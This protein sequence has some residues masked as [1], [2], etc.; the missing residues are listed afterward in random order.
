[1]P[2]DEVDFEKR[3]WLPYSGW[4]FNRAHLLLANLSTGG[5]SQTPNKERMYYS[6]EVLH[7]TKQAPH[8]DNRVVL[9]AECDKL[10]RRKAQMQSCWRNIDIRGVRWTQ[11][12]FAQGI[13][14]A[15]L[16]NEN[17]E[18]VGAR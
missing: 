13:A 15:G 6:F 11:T 7:Q 2:L 5:W 14:R 12:V 4:P 8:A 17:S 9:E 10:G 1:M 18:A 3:D 16:G